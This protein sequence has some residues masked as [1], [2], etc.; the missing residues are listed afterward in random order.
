[1]Q[2]RRRALVPL[3]IRSSSFYRAA[4]F[5]L[6]AASLV[7]CSSSITS[8]ILLRSALQKDL[9]DYLTARSSLEHISTISMTV[10]FGDRQQDISVAAGTTRYGGGAA[11]T[12]A[13]LFQI[14]SNTKAF[15]SV[16]ILQLEAAG[17][18]SIGDALGKWLPQYPAW[19]Q[20]T[21]RQLLNMTSGIPSYDSAPAFESDYSNNPLAEFTPAQLVAYV[22]PAIQTPGGAFV[23]SNTNY[24]LA[25]M[26]VD[27]ASSSQSYQTEVQRIIRQTGLNST[28]YE[29]DFYPQFVTR[30]LVSGYAVNTDLPGLSKLYG[31]DVSGFSLGLAQGAGGMIST[32]DDLTTW[33]RALFEEDVLPP[34]Q[35]QELKSL[36]AIPSGQPIAQTS[37]SQPQAFGLGVFQI[38]DPKLGLYWAYQGTTLGYR[39]TYMYFPNSELIVTYFTNSDTSAAL[40]QISAQLFP[41][42][43]A[44]LQAAGAIQ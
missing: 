6:L 2:T 27:E 8:N 24:I 30:R 21:I 31:Q 16:A 23:Y 22:Y 14:G 7:S 1:M 43:Y 11:V 9:T 42:V 29:P 15:T 13:S 10:S 39:A 4:A 5:G 28:Y 32:P 17:V 18:L 12:P 35:L 44:T 19:S 36:V 3:R 41:A 25:Q 26:I 33:T 37:A 20:V 40:N 38:N 34:K